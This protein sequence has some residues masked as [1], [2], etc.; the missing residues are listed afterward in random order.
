MSSIVDVGLKVLK[1]DNKFLLYNSLIGFTRARVLR[2]F[3]KTCW[4]KKKSWKFYRILESPVLL[5][6]FLNLQCGFYQKFAHH[7]TNL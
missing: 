7:T 3:G 4:T 6:E 2:H 5:L 1:Y